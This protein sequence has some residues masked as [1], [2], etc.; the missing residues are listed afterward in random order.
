MST[1]QSP[2]ESTADESLEDVAPRYTVDRIGEEN[3]VPY[4]GVRAAD[5]WLIGGAVLVVLTIATLGGLTLGAIALAFVALTIGAYLFYVTPAHTPISTWLSN[6]WRYVKRP[7]ATYSAPKEAGSADRNEGGL[8]NKTPF[9][10]DERTEELTGIRRAWVGDGAVLRRDGR[11]E[12]AIEVNPGNMDFAPWTEWRDLQATCQEYVNKH[13]H[14]ELKVNVTTQEFELDELVDRLESRLDDPMIDARP[15]LAALLHEYRQRRPQQMREQG[16]QQHRIFI[17]VTVSPREIEESHVA[18]STPAE[19]TARL[20]VIGSLLSRLPGMDVSVARQ[21]SDLEEHN[22]M[23]DLLD[24]RLETIRDDL[25]AGQPKWAAERVS[26]IELF[27]LERRFWTGTRA[28]EAALD[29]TLRQPAA[30][31]GRRTP[32]SDSSSG[33]ESQESQEDQ[34]DQDDHSHDR[35]SQHEEATHGGAV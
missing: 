6:M 26:T 17:F 33:Q 8:A 20:P 10:P 19:K 9:R 28:T 13:A 27:Q 21:L 15:T 18:E 14:S 3:T 31:A 25:V 11:L 1:D 12:G 34:D 32:T 4:F 23:V 2:S 35:P 30:A 22:E 24:K 5:A 7:S 29:R 16:L